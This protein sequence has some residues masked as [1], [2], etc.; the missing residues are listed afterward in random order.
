MSKS[1]RTD[2]E[3]RIAKR[4][5]ARDTKGDIVLPRIVE[6]EPRR[7][8][9]HPISKRS[10]SRWLQEIPEKYIYGLSGVELRARKTEAIGQ[11][12]GSY[13]LDEKVI[14]LYSLP[15]K[16][17]L[18]HL[19]PTRTQEFRRF[20]ARVSTAGSN[21]SITWPNVEALSHWFCTAIL[22]HE[23]GHHFRNQYKQRRKVG[24]DIDEELVADLHAIRLSNLR[25]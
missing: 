1:L 8:D 3:S 18:Q 25:Q 10:L 23:L 12:Y 9:I 21:S 22:A 15:T 20:G 6:R 14:I 19:R 5:A 24:S 11:P 7:G 16:W 4:N 17:N 13:R 2:R